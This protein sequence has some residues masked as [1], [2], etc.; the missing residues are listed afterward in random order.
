MVTFVEEVVVTLEAIVLEAV[1]LQVEIVMEED[2]VEMV[3]SGLLM[4]TEAL[5]VEVHLRD[6]SK[7]NCC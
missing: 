2:A 4:E 3:L 5:M 1:V 6:L 7:I